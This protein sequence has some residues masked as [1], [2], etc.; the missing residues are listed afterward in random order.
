MTKWRHSVCTKVSQE[1]ILA[2][3]REAIGK[4][5]RQLCE[6]KGVGIVEA[7]VCAD[8]IHMLEE[9]PPKI[10]ASGFMGY[11]NGKS[12][13]MLYG[14]F[15]ELK[16]K[17]RSSACGTE[18]DGAVPLAQQG[19]EAAAARLGVAHAHLVQP[20]FHIGQGIWAGP[21]SPLESGAARGAR[22]PAGPACP[23]FLDRA[24]HAWFGSSLF[25]VAILLRKRCASF[26]TEVKILKK[27]VKPLLLRGRGGKNR[28]RIFYRRGN[29]DMGQ[30]IFAN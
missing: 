18:Q 1:S 10:A 15:D 16:Y 2:K 28:A 5:L 22:L 20:V 21:Y 4:I 11:L 6:W 27:Q 14:Q 23:Q 9:I 26:G 12:G 25:A 7:E 24:V 19:V 3:K 13:T 17:Y 29:L 8:H 30:N